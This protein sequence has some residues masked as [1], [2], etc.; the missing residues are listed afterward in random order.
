MTGHPPK[1][2]LAL[3]IGVVGHRLNRMPEQM[4]SE[5][6]AYIREALKELSQAAET[7]LQRYEGFF[8]GESP[9]IVLMS[10]LAEGADRMAAR[11]AIEQ[12]LALTAVLPFTV[13]AYEHDFRE[14]SSRAE[15]RELVSKAHKTLTLCGDRIRKPAAYEAAGLTILDNSDIILAIWDGKTSA[16]RGG[17]AQ[18]IEVAAKS[19][20]PIIHID[21]TGGHPPHLLW[22]DSPRC[23]FQALT[24][25]IFPSYRLLILCGTSLT[26]WCARRQTT[27]IYLTIPCCLSRFTLYSGCSWR[28]VKRQR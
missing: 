2:R 28:S 23:H 1:P 26:S 10:G 8:G 6:M 4:R 27:R 12:N 7:A 19:D 20:L 17:T 21:P 14:Q 25:P 3:S 9:A 16:G 24:S 13:D 22:A 11:A 5:V 15:Y 18:L